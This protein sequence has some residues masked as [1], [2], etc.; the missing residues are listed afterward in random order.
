MDWNRNSWLNNVSELSIKLKIG[1]LLKIFIKEISDKK[2]VDD[3][4]LI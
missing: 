2:E 3:N 1:L 4:I